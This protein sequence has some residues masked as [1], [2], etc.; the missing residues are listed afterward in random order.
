VLWQDRLGWEC[1]RSWFVVGSPASCR[2]GRS[3]IDRS[4]ASRYIEVWPWILSHSVSIPL[5]ENPSQISRGS[6]VCLVSRDRPDMEDFEF[7]CPYLI[8]Y[9]GYQDPH[10][11]VEWLEF[12]RT[13]QVICKKLEHRQVLGASIVL[14]TSLAKLVVPG[15]RQNSRERRVAE[16]GSIRD[17][18]CPR[19]SDW[20]WSDQ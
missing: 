20:I 5:C 11:Y 9:A 7:G 8:L 13:F 16:L 18:R 15:H 2:H 3:S 10:I 6:T 14:P 1:Q 4:V 19:M 17:S 12:R